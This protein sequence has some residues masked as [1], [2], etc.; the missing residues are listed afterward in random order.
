MNQSTSQKGF[1]ALF[2]SFLIL[3]IIL[4]LG[5]NITV[6]TLGQ[7]K[8][9]ANI[10]ISS[11][12]YYT[13][14]AGL[15]DALL[16]LEK[17]MNWASPYSFQVG[18]ATATVTISNIIGGTRTLDSEGNSFERIRKTQV[19]YQIDTDQISFHFGAQVGEGG[20]TMESNSKVIGNVFSNGDISGTGTGMGGSIITETVKVAGVHTIREVLVNGDAH[21]NTFQDCQVDGEAF[22]V[23]SITNCTVGTQTQI[24]E[25]PAPVALPI[26]DTQINEWKTKAEAGGVITPPGP[27]FEHRISGINSLGPI[28]IDGHLRIEANSTFILTGTVWVTGELR[29]DSNTNIYLDPSFGTLS[30]IFIS[31]GTLR[32]ES[33]ILVCGSEGIQTSPRQCNPSNG[34]FIIF[35]STSPSLDPDQPALRI[36]SDTEAAIAYASKGIIDI[37]SNSSLKEVT[38]F[39][40]RLR[41]NAQIIY[42]IGLQDLSFTS[43]P[44]GGWEVTSWKEVE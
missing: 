19:I 25:S 30:G 44:S 18:E 40:V 16:R 1:A 17:S 15:E 9:A 29:P 21:A 41:S 43:G 13:A 24:S 7:Q 11:Q 35:L 36:D 14:E 34:S 22:Y 4:A 10:T 42:E 39:A 26:S 6:L 23:V 8:I 2:L 20:L 38:G 31:D 37:R 5:V 33:N 12:A 28:K 27:D 3:A 32:L